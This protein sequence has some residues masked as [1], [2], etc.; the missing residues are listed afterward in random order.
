MKTT[1]RRRNRLRSNQSALERWKPSPSIGVLAAGLIL[2]L[3]LGM[4]GRVFDP[5]ASLQEHYLLLA[6]DL[7][8]QGAPI[9]AVRDRLVH[10][11]YT[12]PSVAVVGIADQLASSSDKV[13]QQEADQLHQFAAAL[14]AGPEQTG[15]SAAI[16]AIPTGIPQPTST[17]TATYSLA[18]VAPIVP[19]AIPTV[20]APVTITP[21]AAPPD[22]TAPPLIAQPTAAPASP[23]SSGK[24][25]VIKT[26]NRIPVYLRKDPNSKSAVVAV[27]PSGSSVDI[28][29]VVTGEAVDPAENHWYKIGV[30]GK[31]GYIY[32]KYVQAGG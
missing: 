12:I 26:A 14:A 16:K 3:A 6:S 24:T 1:P 28:K 17:I 15:A 22:S 13:K 11:G 7:Y 29:G 9:A 19:T 31:A 30:N 4:R 27:V 32:S 10:Q 25:G 23:P 8:V 21:T 18:E 5:S 20:S 2:G